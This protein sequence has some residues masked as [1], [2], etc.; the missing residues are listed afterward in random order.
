[1][2]LDPLTAR[3]AKNCPGWCRSLAQ[4]QS[5]ARLGL[6]RCLDPLTP[7]IGVRRLGWCRSLVGPQPTP[8]MPASAAQLVRGLCP[9]H[10]MPE[11]SNGRL[12]H[13]MRNE[14]DLWSST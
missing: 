4:P 9:G 7:R 8:V 2:L 13:E 14:I 11:L 5:T 10:V 6:R 12:A 1:M 3:L